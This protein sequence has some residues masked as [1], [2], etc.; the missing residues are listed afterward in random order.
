[1][2]AILTAVTLFAAVLVA[3]SR[4]PPRMMT[5][6]LWRAYCV[7]RPDGLSVSFACPLFL[8][9]WDVNGRDFATDR[10]V[11]G[12]RLLTHCEN[13]WRRYLGRELTYRNVIV[14]S[15]EWTER[16]VR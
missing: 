6:D 7:L 12:M 2:I 15:R 5:H 1:M 11:N 9:E 4:V 3:L 8:F 10:I 16:E 14:D 13:W